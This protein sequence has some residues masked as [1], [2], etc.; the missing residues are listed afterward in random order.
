MDNAKRWKL[1]C[2]VEQIRNSIWSVK[3]GLIY[4]SAIGLFGTLNVSKR[5]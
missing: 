5:N 3:A 4:I 2:T 1:T